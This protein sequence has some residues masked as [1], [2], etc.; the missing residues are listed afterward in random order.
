MQPIAAT[1]KASCSPECS[2]TDNGGC[3]QR[4]FLESGTFCKAAREQEITD[5]AS[6]STMGS[7]A[8]LQSFTD[9][10]ETCEGSCGQRGQC[11][12][13]LGG[14]APCLRNLHPAFP[15]AWPRRRSRTP[16]PSAPSSCVPSCS[17]GWCK[18][19]TAAGTSC[20]CP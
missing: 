4:G 8:L 3:V 15:A 18:P 10:Y 16:A 12:H 20:G 9:T 11:T 17:S 2:V 14:C 13:R 7:I 6:T 1:F 5:P 19:D